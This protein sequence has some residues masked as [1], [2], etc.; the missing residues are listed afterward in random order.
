[1]AEPN[2]PYNNRV[3]FYGECIDNK[4]PLGLGRIRAVLKTENTTD[5]ENSVKD[6]TG[7]S[8]NDKWTDKDPFVV[9]PLLPVFLN[10]IPKTQD[11][12]VNVKGEFVHLMYSNADDKG[13]KDKFYISGVHSSLTMINEEPYESAVKNGNLGSRDTDRNKL[14]NKKTGEEFDK[15]NVGIYPKPVDIAIN[16]RGSADIVVKEDTVLLRAGKFNTLPTP[17]V[18]PIFNDKRAFIQLT[19]FNEKISYGLP[20][21]YLKFKFEHKPIKTLLEYN[22]QNPENNA[23]PNLYTGAIYIYNLKPSEKTGTRSFDISTEVDE[24]DKSLYFAFQFTAITKEKVIELTNSILQGMVDGLIP[25]LEK[26]TPQVSPVGPYGIRESVFPIY[27]RPQP[28]LYAKANSDTST[29]REKI[30]ITNLMSGIKV[31][32]STNGGYGL[33]Y[34]ETKKDTVPY[35]PEEN[36]EIPK[37]VQA[38]SNTA[39]IM[40]GE[41]LYLLS[42]NSKKDGGNKINLSDTLYGIGPNKVSD[43]IEPYTSSMVRGEELIELLDLIVQFLIGHV[44]PYHGMVPD[45]QSVNGVKFDELLNELRKANQKIL[46][47]YIRIN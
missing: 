17:N 14:R 36:I 27:F 30:F 10:I 45:S 24:E 3:F 33:I 46:N 47:K 25:N 16:G 1:M 15:N 34:D 38:I 4:D 13:N 19:K 6:G 18:Y 8:D 11:D 29:T 5:R 28:S 26:I 32:N 9:R 44:H 2:L 41:Y 22:I 42:H 40:G 12:G 23:D 37:N 43:E 39:G 20:R 7:I 21:K 35:V 31:T